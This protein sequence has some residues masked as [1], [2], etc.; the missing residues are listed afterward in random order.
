MTEYQ[1]YLLGWR[2][3]AIRSVRLWL[4]GRVC[5]TCPLGI[6]YRCIMRRMCGVAE[7]ASLVCGMRREIH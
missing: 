1:G 4:D 5:R 7:A 2:W 6:G 3:W